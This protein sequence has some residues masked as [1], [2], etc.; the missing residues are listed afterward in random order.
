MPGIDKRDTIKDWIEHN[1]VAAIPHVIDDTGETWV[2]FGVISQP[3][4]VFISPDGSVERHTGAMGPVDLG[5]R[6]KAL[7]SS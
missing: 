4:M 7:V 5:D 1:G 6:V 2:T 3:S